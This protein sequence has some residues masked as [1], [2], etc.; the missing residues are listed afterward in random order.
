MGMV[1]PFEQCMR[2]MSSGEINCFRHWSNR[3]YC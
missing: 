2:K 3:S 1:G